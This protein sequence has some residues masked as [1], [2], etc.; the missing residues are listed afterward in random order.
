MRRAFVV[1]GALLGA[2]LLALVASGGPAGAAFP[3]ENGRIAFSAEKLRLGT[4]GVFAVEPDGSGQARLGP[5]NAHS[6][7]WSAD[8]ERVAFAAYSGEGEGDYNEDVYVMDADGSDVRRVTT[9]ARAYESSPSFFPD[10]ETVA[11][12]RYTERTNATD[13]FTKK[14]G[15]A[16]SARLTETPGSYEESVAVSPD[17]RRV[18]YTAYSRTADL[19]VMDADGSDLEN[20]TKT[21]RVDEVGADWSPDGRK[22]AFSSYRFSGMGLAAGARDGGAFSPGALVPESLARATSGPAGGGTQ[23][24]PQEDLEVSVVNADGTGRRD[25]T[26]GPAFDALPAFSPD[27]GKIVFSRI[28]FGDGRQQSELV[29]MGADGAGKRRITDTPRTFEYDADWQPLAPQP[30][31]LD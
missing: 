9:S 14:I 27:G 17:G 12:V 4:S 13:V 20:L 29:V 21:R 15:E 25:L 2:T 16:G 24:E 23:G 10:G 11:F 26:A 7:A 18:A 8:G 6:P 22:L 30:A 5:E 1:L 28:T 3:G 19:F 31:E